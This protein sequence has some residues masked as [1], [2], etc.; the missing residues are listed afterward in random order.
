MKCERRAE[1]FQVN[2]GAR[3]LQAGEIAQ[4]DSQKQEEAWE[5]AG[6]KGRHGDR[7]CCWVA[8]VVS[9]SVR[10]HRRKPA[11]LPRPWGSPGKNTGVGRHWLLQGTVIR[12][13]TRERLP[14]VQCP[15]HG[16]LSPDLIAKCLR[17]YQGIGKDGL[18]TPIIISR[19]D[20]NCYW[21][22][23]ASGDTFHA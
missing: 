8:S 1:V 15:T 4:V 13:R 20:K 12:M 11:R 14:A 5:A 23:P 10:P 21:W 22:Q 7:C 18:S 2:S 9:D 16:K 3:R 6:A 17:S 19:G